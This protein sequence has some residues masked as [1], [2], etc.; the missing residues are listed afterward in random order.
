MDHNN[1]QGEDEGGASEI[2]GQE[3]T[4][5]SVKKMLLNLEKIVNKNRDLRTKFP[6]DPEK[7]SPLSVLQITGYGKTNE[8]DM[9]GSID[10][11][12][13]SST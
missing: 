6:S 13:R 4:S 3:L 1:P 7:Y 8:V 2:P 9:V 10:S 12:I 11:L 5:Q